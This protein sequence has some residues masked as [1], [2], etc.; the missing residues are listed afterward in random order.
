MRE[1]C[2]ESHLRGGPLAVAL[3]R[4]HRPRHLPPRGAPLS[5]NPPSARSFR[6]YSLI[7]GI[8]A[9]L[10]LLVSHSWGPAVCDRVGIVIRRRLLILFPP[11]VSTACAHRRGECCDLR[12]C[13]RCALPI[14][15]ERKSLTQYPLMPNAPQFCGAFGA[16]GL[17]AT[18]LRLWLAVWW[19][20][21]H[22]PFP[23]PLTRPYVAR[24]MSRA[25][26]FRWSASDLVIRGSW[27]RHK[28]AQ[29]C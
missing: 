11:K 1:F 26:T 25:T 2:L 28:F 14:N 15:F 24:Y 18:L 27:E 4:G 8:V 6:S 10:C 16:F 13:L 17:Q 20:K 19:S 29:L 21:S 3:G 23:A 7:C 22:G 5:R 9:A 12:C